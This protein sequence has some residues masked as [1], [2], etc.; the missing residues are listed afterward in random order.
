MQNNPV[1]LAQLIFKLH[2]CVLF[3]AIPFNLY[4]RVKRELSSSFCAPC[5]RRCPFTIL[6]V[7]ILNKS[8]KSTIEEK[9]QAERLIVI[10]GSVIF[11]QQMLL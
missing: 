11:L 3:T 10:A 1:T 8:C 7:P 2:I 5:F 4:S 9:L 6:N